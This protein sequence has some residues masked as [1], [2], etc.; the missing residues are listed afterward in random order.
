MK[1]V[2]CDTFK[3]ALFWDE[4]QLSSFYRLVSHSGTR[5]TSTEHESD[6]YPSAYLA[7]LYKQ[8][9]PG[10]NEISSVE[11]GLVLRGHKLALSC[12]LVSVLHC[13]DWILLKESRSLQTTIK[14]IA[15]IKTQVSQTPIKL[16]PRKTHARTH[17]HTIQK[18]LCTIRCLK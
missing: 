6:T 5:G 1:F 10:S 11:A 4:A 3:V 14:L 2:T 12:Q 8:I 15:V 13:A 16:L 17:T 7:P 9:S 18:L